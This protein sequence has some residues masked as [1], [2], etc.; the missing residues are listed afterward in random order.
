MDFSELKNGSAFHNVD[1]YPG[2]FKIWATEDT[3]E[4][5]AKF[6]EIVEE[7]RRMAAV[8]GYEIQPHP[9]ARDPFG[10]WDFAAINTG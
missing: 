1:H 3:E 2:G 5:R 4:C 8:E 7:A 10:R 9:S 6:H